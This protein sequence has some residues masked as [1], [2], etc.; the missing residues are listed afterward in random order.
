LLSSV[1]VTLKDPVIP[2]RQSFPLSIQAV[3][4][5]GCIHTMSI[6]CANFCWNTS[7]LNFV[8]YGN[9]S[10]G[11]WRWKL[12]RLQ[13]RWDPGAMLLNAPELIPLASYNGNMTRSRNSV[14]V[15][16]K[17][18]RLE[19]W[20]LFMNALLIVTF[21]IRNLSWQVGLLFLLYKGL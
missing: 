17:L 1:F 12:R 15:Q 10:M 18:C 16:T 9:A 21:V 20:P 7:M 13:R 5:S 4:I 6:L 11:Q 3:F 14:V 8:M 2:T 19:N